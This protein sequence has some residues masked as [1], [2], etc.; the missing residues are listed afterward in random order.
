M[1]A[2]VS[3]VIEGLARLAADEGKLLRGS[4]EGANKLVLKLNTIQ[5]Y[6]HN[7][8]MIAM[9][10][11]RIRGWV[12]RLKTVLYEADDAIDEWHTKSQL[13]IASHNYETCLNTVNYFLTTQCTNCYHQNV[14]HIN[15]GKKI[16]VVNNELA[17]IA[18]KVNSFKFL[19][20]PVIPGRGN[21]ALISYDAILKAQ[22]T[23]ST[24]E[25]VIGRGGKLRV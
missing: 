5:P 11:P 15:I 20:N 17:D 3:D 12:T 7:A 13:G 10:D 25:N 6:L 19:E 22:M 18:N 23:N 9:T 8:E 2:F 21:D 4:R 24:K 16:E 1:D 14:V